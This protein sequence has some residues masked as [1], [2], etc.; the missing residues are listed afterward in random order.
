MRKI[1]KKFLF[2]IFLLFITQSLKPNTYTDCVNVPTAEVVDYGVG[3]ITSRIY[4]GGGVILRFVFSPF[5]RF[6]FGGSLDIDCLIGYETPEVRDPAFYVK[7]RIFDGTKVFPAVALGYDGQ[8]YNFVSNK[9]TLPAKGLY[10][11]FSQNIVFKKLFTDFGVN[12]TKYEDKQ[13]LFGFLSL[14]FTLEDFIFLAV[15]YENIYE[16]QIQQVNCLV[17]FIL[18]KVASVDLILNNLGAS[19]QKIERQVRI[20]YIYKFF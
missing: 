11:V 4:S 6:N 10:L 8:G 20:N 17:S 16:R 13:K 9:Y 14:R 15:E 7:W 1:L 3:C 19:E 18:S 2:F 5:N 12:L